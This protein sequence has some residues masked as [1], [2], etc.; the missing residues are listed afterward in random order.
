MR[1]GFLGSGEEREGEGGEGIRAGGMV[2]L[3]LE[4]ALC[5]GERGRR[6]EAG[7]TWG[8]EGGRLVPRSKYFN[9]LQ[10]KRKK[11]SAS[12]ISSSF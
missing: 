3:L 11:N 2:G 1:P 7:E 8:K 4:L 12:K 9:S 10:L 6:Q 5:V